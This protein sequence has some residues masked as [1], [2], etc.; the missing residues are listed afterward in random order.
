LRDVSRKY[1]SISDRSL[2]AEITSVRDKIRS[3]AILLRAAVLRNV[4]SRF[5]VNLSIWY[6]D[7]YIQWSVHPTWKTPFS[8]LKL[9]G[10]RNLCI[11][12]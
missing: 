4:L 12:A 7:G 3:S 1:V 5:T 6:R 8:T 10:A 11:P 9:A 2:Q